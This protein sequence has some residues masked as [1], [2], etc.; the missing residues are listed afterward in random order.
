MEHLLVVFLFVAFYPSELQTNFKGL[1]ETA[2]TLAKSKNS[3]VI[4]LENQ[5]PKLSLKINVCTEQ[6]YLEDVGFVFFNRTL[7]RI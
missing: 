1:M 6:T 7:T 5:S 3:H 2:K 4:W